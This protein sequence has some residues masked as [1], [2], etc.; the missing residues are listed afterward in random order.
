MAVSFSQAVGDLGSLLYWK[1]LE[2]YISWGNAIT[3]RAGTAGDCSQFLSS[4]A[5]PF[6]KR[7]LSSQGE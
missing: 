6:Y 3:N 2:A 7:E 5:A 4:E 1:K